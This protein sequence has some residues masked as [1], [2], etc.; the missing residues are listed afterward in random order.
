MENKGAIILTFISGALLILAGSVGSLGLWSLLPTIVALLSLPA[1]I[2]AGVNLLLTALEFIASLGGVAVIAGGVL[3]VMHRIGLG[4]L[5]IGLGAGLGIFSFIVFILGMVLT[6]L[7]NYT[8]ILAVFSTPGLLGAFL[9]IVARFMA[10][11]S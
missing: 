6:N 5:V 7:W 9:S 3:L 11:S 10:K 4:K 8:W 1:E 2:V